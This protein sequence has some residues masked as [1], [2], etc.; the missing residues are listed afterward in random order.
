MSCPC[1]RWSTAA[2][3]AAKPVWGGVYEE[4]NHY[5]AKP[6]QDFIKSGVEEETDK[7]FKLKKNQANLNILTVSQR[8]GALDIRHG[9]RR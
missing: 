9:F 8:D 6:D 3:C 4:G 5:L 1:S 7:P 2:G